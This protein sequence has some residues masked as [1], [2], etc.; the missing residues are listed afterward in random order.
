MQNSLVYLVW[1]ISSKSLGY[2]V[3]T[4]YMAFDRTFGVELGVGKHCQKW[5]TWKL[6]ESC[7]DSHAKSFYKPI[8]LAT[9]TKNGVASLSLRLTPSWW[10]CTL[11][12]EYLLG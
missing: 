11:G 4:T 12:E 1:Y 5:Q 6:F 7:I 2:T 10:I 3:G 9:F 8:N